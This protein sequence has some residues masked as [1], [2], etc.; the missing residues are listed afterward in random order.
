MPIK[1]TMM[2]HLSDC[3]FSRM[4]VLRNTHQVTNV[5]ENVDE[6][7]PTWITGGNGKEGSHCG[8]QLGG[9]SKK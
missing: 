4:A 2:Y 8:K 9:S 7:K 6:L 1:A 3:S 5:S